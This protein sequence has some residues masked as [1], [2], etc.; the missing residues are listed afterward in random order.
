MFQTVFKI[1]S[2]VLIALSLSIIFYKKQSLETSETDVIT[3]FFGRF[4][5]AATPIFFWS[6]ITLSPFRCYSDILIQIRYASNRIHDSHN[7][8][9]NDFWD[10]SE[11]IVN[12]YLS[13]LSYI[14]FN[15]FVFLAYFPIVA[16][17]S[18]SG[19]SPTHSAQV[20]WIH[21]V[22][23]KCFPIWLFTLARRGAVL[24]RS[25]HSTYSVPRQIRR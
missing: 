4:F 14:S 7:F 1:C 23:L 10:T 21:P 25:L 3:H 18:W 5:V 19:I 9:D 13:F 11:E 2:G 16:N 17:H 22:G 15:K 24:P 20:L 6:G 8:T 12:R